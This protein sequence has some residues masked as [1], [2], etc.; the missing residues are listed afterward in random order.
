MPRAYRLLVIDIDGTLVDRHGN[1]SPEDKEALLDVRRS[2]LAVTL[3]TGRAM[4]AC[5]GIIEQLALDGYHIFFDGA[6]V[7]DPALGREVYARPVDRLTVVE[8]V[9]FARRH[10]VYLELFTATAFFIERE[11]WATEIR[12]RFFDLE[13][14]MVNFN[15]ISPDERI[16]KAQIITASAEEA[17]LAKEFC[18]HF[19]GRLNF[20]WAKT[21]AYPAVDFINVV[22]PEVSKGKALLAL[23]SHLGVGLAEVM[24]IGD[25]LNDIPL[26]ATAGLAVAMENAPDEVREVADYITTDVDH[27]G[28]AAAVKKYL[29]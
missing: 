24:A 2:G 16:I 19:D 9:E 15:D 14:K 8:M 29:L 5:R 20:S 21:P 25:G 13:P 3:S 28:V 7:S 6:L 27:N 18:E 26:L 17:A 4:P 23:T 1:I 12:R 11:T 22:D 10:D